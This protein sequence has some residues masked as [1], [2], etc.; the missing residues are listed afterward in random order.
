MTRIIIFANGILTDPIAEAARWIRPGDFIVAADG[1][2][3]HAL[4]AGIT[5]DHV[6]GDL[7]SLSS[8][9]RATLE[10]AGTIVHAHPP[11]KDETD[12]E[13]ALIWAAT[14]S[15]IAEIVVLGVLGFI[16]QMQTAKEYVIEPPP[17]RI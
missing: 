2:T 4:A 9:L 6:I 14:Q 13:L 15:H 17:N 3:R 16:G 7:D 1:G 10:A 11:A 12:L 8:E 5:P